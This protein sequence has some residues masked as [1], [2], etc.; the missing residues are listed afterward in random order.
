MD[1]ETFEI[2]FDGI[3]T[4]LQASVDLVKDHENRLTGDQLHKI[5]FLVYDLTKGEG[6]F[7]PSMNVKIREKYSSKSAPPK[8]R[9]NV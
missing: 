6:F 7:G 3:D 2:L 1:E 5:L 8:V 4:Q 9:G